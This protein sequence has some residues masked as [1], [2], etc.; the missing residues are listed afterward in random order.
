MTT[1]EQLDKLLASLATQYRKLNVKQ[2][3]FAIKEIDRVRLEITD[4]LT[5]YADSEGL[6]KKQRLNS[7]LRE[8]EAIEKSVRKHGMDALESVVGETSALVA[9]ESSAALTATVGASA[10]SGVTLDVIDRNVMRYVV[11]RF[12]DDGLVLSDRVWNFAGDQRA[13]LS[14]VL[15]SGIIRGESVNQLVASVRKVYANETWKIR[16]LVVTEGATAQ[17]VSEAY[18]AQQSPAVKALRIHRGR[19]NKPEHNCTK[20]ELADKHGMGRGI[21]LPTDSEIFAPHVNCTSW[22]S[23]VL[24]DKEVR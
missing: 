22:L 13:E 21:Y 4:M 15:R 23:Y 18:F 2:Q 7:L 8:L 14:K 9:A 17:R 6:I 10:V 19:A 16:R 11:N 5:E 12:G 1:Q 20:L 3:A 24:H